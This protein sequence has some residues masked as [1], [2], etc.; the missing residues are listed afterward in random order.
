MSTKPDMILTVRDLD[1]MPDDGKRYEVIDGELFVSKTP[2]LFHQLISGTIYSRFDS[3]LKENPIGKVVS[4]PGVILSDLDGVIPDLVFISME[5]LAAAVESD[6]IHGAPELVVEI[7][8][9]GSDNARRDRIAKL[10]LYA[11]FGVREYWIV[12][13]E[14]RTIE[15]YIRSGNNLI[16]SGT[17]GG[18]DEISS[19]VLPGYTC[20]VADLFSI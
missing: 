20:K 12:D 1:L 17:F 4:T 5:K 15:L 18:T 6:R 9:P 3:Y 19:A 11:K 2:G 8:S 14:A 7:L 10:Y 16:L 13:P